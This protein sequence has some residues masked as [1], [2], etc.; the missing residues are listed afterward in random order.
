MTCRGRIKL[1][2]AVIKP[3]QN[4][5]FLINRGVHDSFHLRAENESDKQKWLNA[6]NSGISLFN[7][8][9]FKNTY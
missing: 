9:H 8:L 1:A 6:L 4:S 7:Y 3:L 5:N 2:S